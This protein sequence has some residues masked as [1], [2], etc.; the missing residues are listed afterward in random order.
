M[1]QLEIAVFHTISSG[2]GNNLSESIQFN[3]I[4]VRGGTFWVRVS[5]SKV[6]FQ[7]S[8]FQHSLQCN[9]SGVAASCA[10]I[11][12]EHVYFIFKPRPIQSTR[13]IRTFDNR[14]NPNVCRERRAGQMLSFRHFFLPHFSVPVREWKYFFSSV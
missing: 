10:R 14:M 3:S 8:N 9:S 1:P 4:C 12:I 2:N 6:I 11:I 7:Y 5:F 13:V